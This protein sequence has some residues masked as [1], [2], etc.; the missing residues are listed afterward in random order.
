MRPLNPGI[1]MTK[2]ITK[3]SAA[4][5]RLPQRPWLMLRALK[6]RWTMAWLVP[7]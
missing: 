7:Q 3:L 1:T 2:K 5:K 6:V 4:A